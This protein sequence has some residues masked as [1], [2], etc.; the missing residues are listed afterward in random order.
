MADLSG[1]QRTTW[2]Q[3]IVVIR[4]TN[5]MVRGAIQLILLKDGIIASQNAQV[6]RTAKPHNNETSN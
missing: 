4:T 1:G 6:S 5:L 2:N 3:I